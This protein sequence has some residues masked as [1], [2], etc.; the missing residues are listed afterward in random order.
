MFA[1]KQSQMLGMVLFAFAVAWMVAYPKIVARLRAGKVQARLAEPKAS[2]ATGAAPHSELARDDEDDDSDGPAREEKTPREKRLDT[3]LRIA[4]DGGCIYCRAA[5]TRP[6]P[7]LA[8]SPRRAVIEALIFDTVPRYW[9]VDEPSD[10]KLLCDG[11]FELAR[12]AAEV[13][14]VELHRGLVKCVSEQQQ[15][16]LELNRH[17]FDELMLLEAD[18]V[19]KAGVA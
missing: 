15:T 13:H 19:R 7:I 5:A 16:R 11:H 12:S 14:A 8:F 3:I 6:Y 17:R 10:Q 18:R 2:D 9:M 4:A 1:D